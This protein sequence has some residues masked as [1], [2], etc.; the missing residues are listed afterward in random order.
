M[1]FE[2]LN[3]GRNIFIPPKICSINIISHKTLGTLKKLAQKENKWFLT[4]W[5]VCKQPCHNNP[6]E[7]IKFYQSSNIELSPNIY[8]Y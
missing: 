2:T 1:K 6:T 7:M 8:W 3:L 4:I 5:N